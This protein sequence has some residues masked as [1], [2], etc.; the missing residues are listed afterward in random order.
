MKMKV[1][2]RPAWLLALC[3]CSAASAIAQTANL[4]GNDPGSLGDSKANA[5]EVC[6]AAGQRAYLARLLCADGSRPEI[7]RVGSVG[8]RTEPRAPLSEEQERE[9][10]DAMLRGLPLKAGQPDFHIVDL[11]QA[12]CGQVQRQ[13]YL[14]MYHCDNPAPAQAPAGFSLRAKPTASTTP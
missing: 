6:R 14:D 7:S 2:G 5:I 9:L 10:L 1:P 13:L 8:S 11:Y 3:L 12:T 4:P